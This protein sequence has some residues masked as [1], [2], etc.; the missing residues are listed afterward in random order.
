MKWFLCFARAAVVTASVVCLFVATSV[1]EACPFCSAPSLT[2]TEQLAKADAAVQVQWAGG[3]KGDGKEKFGNTVYEV[4]QVLRDVDKKLKKG[5]RITLERYRAGK[6]GDLSLLLG[7]KLETLEWGSPLE[8]SETSFNYVVQAPSPESAPDKRLAYFLKFLEFSDPLVSN[9]AY[10]EFANAPYKDIVLLSK[11]MPR[12]KL[13]KWLTDPNLSAT[14]IG[15]YGLMLGLCGEESDAK[16]MEEKIKLSSEEF[17]L[18]IDGV[19]GGYLLLT[20]NDGLKVIEQSKFQ[21]KKVPF[22]ETYAAMQALRFMWTYGDG[23]IPKDRLQ[24]SMRLLLDRPELA[25]LV[26][27]DLARWKD[28]TVIPKLMAMYGDGEFNVPSI[29]RATVRYML[30]CTKDVPKPEPGAASIQKTT[31]TPHVAEATKSLETLRQK[32]PKTVSEAERFFFLP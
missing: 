9:D 25:D 10:A 17:R 19:M 2:L 6:K 4:I 22:S 3:D 23:R 11:Q 26:I 31:E 12:D 27:S 18:G 16:L 15:L 5:D 1:T 13:R 7:S 14:R 29:K 30:A 20:G 32:D 24:A 28:W 21:N 8:V